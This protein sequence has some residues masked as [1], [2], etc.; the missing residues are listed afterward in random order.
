MAFTAEAEVPAYQTIY[1]TDADCGRVPRS[2]YVEKEPP[3]GLL[4]HFALVLPDNHLHIVFGSG[5]A[6]KVWCWQ[7][8][9]ALLSAGQW[10]PVADQ[11][12]G[13]LAE[14]GSQVLPSDYLSGLI[15]S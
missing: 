13:M 7:R 10:P 9:F 12:C 11:F 4:F 6:T 3:E 15:R 1:T 14:C 8:K 5:G 2:L